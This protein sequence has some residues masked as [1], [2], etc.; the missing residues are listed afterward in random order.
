MKFKREFK[1]YY[2]ITSSIYSNSI[3]NFINASFGFQHNRIVLSESGYQTIPIV[4]SLY[5]AI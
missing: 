2:G 3:F 5:G 1:G 4:V